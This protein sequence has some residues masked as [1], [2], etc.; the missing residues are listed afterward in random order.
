MLK[1]TPQRLFDPIG[2]PDQ[3]FNP[4]SV[5]MTSDLLPVLVTPRGALFNDDCLTLLRAMKSE[6]VDTVFADPPF[7]IGKEYGTRVNDNL[8]DTS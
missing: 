3:D 8:L 7:N 6:T 4:M 2:A 1:I 5:L